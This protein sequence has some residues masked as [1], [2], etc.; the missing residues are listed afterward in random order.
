[1]RFHEVGR[2]SSPDGPVTIERAVIYP[3]DARAFWYT[4]KR[5]S[6]DVKANYKLSRE[7]ID[8]RLHWCVYRRMS[9]H[10]GPVPFKLSYQLRRVDGLLEYQPLC[11]AHLCNALLTHG[12]AIDG[13]DTGLGKT[14]CSLATCR[15][16][17]LHPIVVC[18]L[19]GI[20]SWRRACAAMRVRPLAIV[21]WELAK[22]GK[23]PYT[24]RAMDHWT[25]KPSYT[26]RVP[27]NTIVIFDEAHKANQDGSQN[28]ALY[29]ASKG[30]YSLSLTASVADRLT[31][32]RPL[33]HLLDIVSWQ[34]FPSWIRKWGSFLD[35]PHDGEP[36]GGML[37]LAEQQDLASINRLLY[38]HYGYRLSYRDP[39]VK[40]FFPEAA[41]QTEIVNLSHTATALQNRL[42]N[43]LLQEVENYREQGKQAD[44]L[45]A[46]LRYRQETELLKVPPLVS[47]ARTYIEQGHSVII[48]VNFRPTLR[49]LA[50]RIHTR[51]IIYGGQGEER[52]GVIGAFQRN[53]SRILL[54]MASAGGE[55]IS[56]HDIA[57]GRPRVSLICPTYDPVVLR[58]VLG[59]T[60]R[61]GS[62]TIPVM[63]LVYAAGTV[64]EKVSTVVN[65]KL[66]NISAI[67]DGDLMEP[68]LF[69]LH[70]R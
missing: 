22:S 42:Y 24:L 63:K 67:N 25:G 56:L 5:T 23:F 18:K 55:S 52:E 40:K 50:D 3:A 10:A 48:F 45:V 16:L 65:A 41:Y 27:D 33:F 54:C 46:D 53:E 17:S 20:S 69:S 9:V 8:G 44:A 36:V 47:I 28:S 21:N 58:Q 15:E 34:E 32:L 43:K 6:P 39:A 38:P 60:R 68:D 64:E 31:R 57:G 61:A 37:S 51:S 11:V 35:P 70:S 1:M 26:W 62:K 49:H 4:W 19:A 14:F 30:I 29:T 12:A 66:N 7:R 59:R 13:S 2:A